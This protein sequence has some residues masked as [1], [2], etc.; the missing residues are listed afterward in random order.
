MKR[1]KVS[2]D[3]RRGRE[4]REGGHTVSGR[5]KG[6]MDGWWCLLYTPHWT[7]LRENGEVDAN[8]LGRSR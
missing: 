4:M 2:Q 1:I 8:M 5:Y 3:P 6:R 7:R